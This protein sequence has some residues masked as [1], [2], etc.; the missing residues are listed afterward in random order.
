MFSG[1]HQALAA[2]ND[3]IALHFRLHAHAAHVHRLSSFRNFDAACKSMLHYG[4]WRQGGAS[5]A[6]R[7]ISQSGHFVVIVFV[8]GNYL[9][10][11]GLA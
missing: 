11:F 6:Q 1:V 8:E 7:R 9:N 10:Y 5:A 4:P 2:N 3:Q